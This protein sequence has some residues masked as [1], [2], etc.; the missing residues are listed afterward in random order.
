[1]LAEA[2]ASLAL[3]P[4][5]NYSSRGNFQ[6]KTPPRHSKTSVTRKR[7]ARSSKNS[8]SETLKRAAYVASHLH[9][10]LIF[11]PSLPAQQDQGGHRPYHS[12]LHTTSWLRVRRWSIVPLSDL[13]YVPSRVASYFIP[14]A[15]LGAYFAWRYYSSS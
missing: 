2:G 14:L 15:L 8:T 4:P 6:A 13:I 1:M 12:I 11:I 7:L 3:P 9:C 10:A 5:H